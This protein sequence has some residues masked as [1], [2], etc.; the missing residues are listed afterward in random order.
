MR[1]LTVRQPYADAIVWGGKATENRG[2]PV[3]GMHLGTTI[4]I[5]AGK[6][7]HAS[8]V[9]A[10]DLELPHAP[11]VRGAII[12]TAVLDS[13]HE[14]DPNGCCAPWGMLGFWHWTLRAAR[15]LSRPVPADGAL[16]LWTPTADVVGK[17]LAA[18]PTIPGAAL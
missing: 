15:P 9:T 2:R 11:D 13:C 3:S 4:L 12:G 6:E 17:V 8:K 7:L 10:A 1:A 5:H 16:G 18:D 14:A